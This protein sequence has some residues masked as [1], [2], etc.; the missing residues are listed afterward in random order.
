MQMHW[1][2]IS[3]ESQSLQTLHSKKQYHLHN[4]EYRLTPSLRICGGETR[5]KLAEEKVYTYEKRDLHRSI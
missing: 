3:S 1:C 2:L 4:L 5:K